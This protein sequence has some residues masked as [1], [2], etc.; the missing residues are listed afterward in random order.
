MESQLG[1]IWKQ[2]VRTLSWLISIFSVPL[3]RFTSLPKLLYTGQSMNYFP[4]FALLSLILLLYQ[5]DYVGYFSQILHALYKYYLFFVWLLGAA[6]DWFICIRSIRLASQVTVSTISLCVNYSIRTV[7]YFL[8]L[9][10]F[11]NFDFKTTSFNL[12]MLTRSIKAT[13]STP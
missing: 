11:L 9:L 8:L 3:W 6:T 10:Y 5:G 4:D 2:L 12:H 13:V 1:R 7:I